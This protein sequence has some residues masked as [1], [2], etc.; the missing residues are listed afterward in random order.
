[1]MRLASAA[2]AAIPGSL[3][4]FIAAVFLAYGVN[5]F[6]TIYA[7][8][9]H[10]VHSVALWCS[11]AS[12]VVAAGLWTA[13][14]AKKELIEKAVLSGGDAA[15]SEQRRADMWHD[16]ALKALLYLGGA[17]AASIFAMVIL[18]VP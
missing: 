12:S 9:G 17:A 4:V 5:A 13:L 18:V 14:S 8:P 3:M 15:T 10:P 2:A 6:T 7:D 11:F 1:M 16:I